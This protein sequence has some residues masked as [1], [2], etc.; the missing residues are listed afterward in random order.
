MTFLMNRP[1][2][3]VHIQLRIVPL[4]L[5]YFIAIII[6][7]A[8]SNLKILVKSKILQPLSTHLKAIKLM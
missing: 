5:I 3:G 7:S 6:P 2:L 8:F 4:V 1:F